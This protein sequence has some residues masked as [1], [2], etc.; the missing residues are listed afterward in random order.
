MNPS[1]PDGGVQSVYNFWLGL[2]PQFFGQLGAASPLAST[3]TPSPAST[4]P[5]PANQI[6]KAATMTQDALQ[7]IARAY[8]PILEAAGAPGLLGQW[9]SA[10]PAWPGLPG[11]AN[12]PAGAAAPSAP[13]P[14]PANPFMPGAQ[15]MQ[16]PFAAMFPAAANPMASLPSMASMFAGAQGNA[17]LPFEAMQKSWTDLATRMAGSTPDAYS[18]AFD[19]THGALVDALGLGPMRRLQVAY[20]DLLGA[21]VARDQARLAYAMVVQ[22]A[23]A[24]SG[25][26]V[27]SIF[28]LLRMWAVSTEEAVHETLQSENGLAATAALARTGIHYRRRMQEIAGIVADTLDMATRNDL[29]E[30]YREIQNLKREVRA[31]RAHVAGALVGPKQP[32]QVV[33]VATLPRTDATGQIRRRTLRDALVADGSAG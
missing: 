19:R 31:M 14:W 26:R 12:P 23:L 1:T 16:N 33:Q 6:A 2:I 13:S 22:G 9:A 18:A 8:S 25:E 32:R 20:Q 11:N 24:Q 27:D 17:G 10:M 29:D 15:A 4:L 21:G 7:S 3:A 5:F 30:A 28:A